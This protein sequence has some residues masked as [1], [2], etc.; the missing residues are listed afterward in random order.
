MRPGF[1]C[2][3]NFEAGLLRGYEATSIIEA[4]V[5]DSREGKLNNSKTS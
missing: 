3:V 5:T 4:T 1:G 2:G